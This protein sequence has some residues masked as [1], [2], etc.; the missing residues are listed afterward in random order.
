[1]ESMQANPLLG[2]DLRRVCKGHF[3]DSKNPCFMHKEQF[4]IHENVPGA[5]QMLLPTVA[6]AYGLSTEV[7]HKIW[8]SE[9][10]VDSSMLQGKD[11][12]SAIDVINPDNRAKK[13]T[14]APLFLS[15][16]GTKTQIASES[17]S[18][19]GFQP[20]PSLMSPMPVQSPVRKFNAFSYQNI[21]PIIK[22]M[23]KFDNGAP[24]Q[25]ADI[26]DDNIHQVLLPTSYHI[27]DLCVLDFNAD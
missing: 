18:Q 6:S 16:E 8:T 5:T 22:P 15:P 11:R 13:K 26:E 17:W 20:L 3:M 4:L 10:N 21:E 19:I 25:H 12:S 23:A 7:I 2:R 9:N 14:P 27:Q 24:Q 1:M